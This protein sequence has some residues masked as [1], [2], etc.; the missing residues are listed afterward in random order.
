MLDFSI[1]APLNNAMPGFPM[2]SLSQY[3]I[4]TRS[5]F[6]KGYAISGYGLP[7]TNAMSL[8]LDIESLRDRITSSSEATQYKVVSTEELGDSLIDR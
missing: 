2:P 7:E 3:L 1:Y 4:K 6:L 5:S 8:M